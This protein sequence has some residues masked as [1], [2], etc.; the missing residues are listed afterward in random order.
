MATTCTLRA[1]TPSRA[2]TSLRLPLG[3]G[4]AALA[5]NTAA[6]IMHARAT[7][8]STASQ[9]GAVMGVARLAGLRRRE[10]TVARTVNVA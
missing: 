1:Q 2:L 4:V 6:P 5:Y 8:S 10:V 9:P 7:M 3:K